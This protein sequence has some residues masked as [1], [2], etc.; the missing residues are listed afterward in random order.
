MQLLDCSLSLVQDKL[1]ITKS[2]APLPSWTI[3]S[4]SMIADIAVEVGGG[5]NDGRITLDPIKSIGGVD[6]RS[7]TLHDYDAAV[8]IMLDLMN[9]VLALWRLID[10]GR[11]LGLDD[12]SRVCNKRGMG[13][14]SKRSRRVALMSHSKGF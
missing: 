7:A 10:Q 12:L 11:K 2:E 6:P 1:L 3:A 13:V 4:P 14:A 9:P 5:A 8:A